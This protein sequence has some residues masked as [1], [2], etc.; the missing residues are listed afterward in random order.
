MDPERPSA[1]RLKLRWVASPDEKLRWR[2]WDGEWVVYHCPSGDTHRL[3]ELS[4][5]ALRIL[6]QEPLDAHDLALQVAS[7][8][9][10]EFDEAFRARIRELVAQFDELG[11]LQGED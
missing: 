8:L 9:G 3:N 5:R 2:F 1:Q 7:R 4:A 11:I 6:Q 10:L